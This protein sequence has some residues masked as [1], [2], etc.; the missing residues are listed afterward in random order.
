MKFGKCFQGLTKPKHYMYALWV[1]TLGRSHGRSRDGRPKG[2][3]ATYEMTL[4]CISLVL[5]D[6]QINKFRITVFRSVP[7]R[8]GPCRSVPVRAGPCRSVPVRAAQF[9]AWFAM[10]LLCGL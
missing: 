4:K 8:A 7:V 9:V 3:I 2:I 6:S 10:Q 1:P 5:I